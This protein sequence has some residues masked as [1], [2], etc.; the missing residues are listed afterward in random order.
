MVFHVNASWNNE[1]TRQQKSPCSELIKKMRNDFYSEYLNKIIPHI[2][3]YLSQMQDLEL[4]NMDLY[5]I[6]SEIIICIFKECGLDIPDLY[7]PTYDERLF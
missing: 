1:F 4:S 2:N 6:S 3:T 7:A 5:N